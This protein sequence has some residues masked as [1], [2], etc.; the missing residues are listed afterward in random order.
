METNNEKQKG[1]KKN[2]SYK[3]DF[4]KL[5][6]GLE[7]GSGDILNVL[8]GFKSNIL[9]DFWKQMIG[10]KFGKPI[11][12]YGSHLSGWADV[13]KWQNFPSL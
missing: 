1:N 2:V 6:V 12:I 5:Y 13:G 11:Y 7:S 4:E 10:S 3:G 8:V 9:F